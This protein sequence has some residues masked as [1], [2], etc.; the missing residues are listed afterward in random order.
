MVAICLENLTLDLVQKAFS[1]IRD[2]IVCSPISFSAAFS[3]LVDSDTYLKYEGAQLTGSFK[4]RGALFHLSKLSGEKKAK[5]VFACSA[6]NH[7]LAVAYA[8]SKEAIPCTIY[9]PKH[10]DSVKVDKIMQLGAKVE[11]S[12]YPGYDDTLAW[13]EEIVSTQGLS[14]I[15]AFNDP[16]IM[17]GNGGTLALELLEQMSGIEN[18]LFP[19][20]GG[21]LAAG[22]CYAMKELAPHIRLIGCQHQDSPSLFLSLQQRKAVTKLPAIETL[23]S[24]IEGGIGENCFKILQDRIDNVC[25]ASEEEIQRGVLWLLEKEQYL[26]EPSSAVTIACCLGER[27]PLLKGKTVVILTGRNVSFGTLKKIYQKNFCNQ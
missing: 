1:T 3:E 15:S 4:I 7:G 13:A 20:G 8:A 14:L 27:P 26:V 2:S 22:L 6:G 11:Y 19:V 18:I 23:A 5:G 9:V 17:A 12:A 21:G 10:A 16:L 24:G 25:L